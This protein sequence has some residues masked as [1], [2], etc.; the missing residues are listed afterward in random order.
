MVRSRIKGDVMLC[1]PSFGVYVNFGGERATRLGVNL[2]P[3]AGINLCPLQWMQPL[4]CVL[5]KINTLTHLRQDP[6]FPTT[7]NSK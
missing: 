4:A 2:I 5:R 3:R 1:V 7:G 6:C